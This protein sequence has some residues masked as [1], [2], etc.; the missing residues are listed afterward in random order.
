VTPPDQTQVLPPTPSLTPERFD[1]DGSG[2]APAVSLV[3]QADRTSAR[4][5]DSI[6]YTITVVNSGSG[7]ASNVVISDSLPEGLDIVEVVATRGDV[8]QDGR[9]VTVTI[10]D[11][12]A[13]ETVTI[14][15]RGRVQEGV[16]SDDLNNL[17]EIESGPPEG[18][19]RQQA[20]VQVALDRPTQVSSMQGGPAIT[21]TPLPR[22]APLPE[23]QPVV[24]RL[25]RTGTLFADVSDA[26]LLLVLAAAAL[27]CLSIAVRTYLSRR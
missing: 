16:S 4:P 12:L 27:F 18:R 5:G 24:A 7:R 3:K 13:G 10:G 11:L 8:V 6:A 17:A 25:P 19:T 20:T 15:V 9:R 23:G 2:R 14:V 22:S 21:P 1:D 26:A